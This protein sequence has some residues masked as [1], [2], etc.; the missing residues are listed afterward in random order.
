MKCVFDYSRKIISK[1]Q[2]R[3][4]VC[5]LGV[6]VAAFVYSAFALENLCD[7]LE[8][9]VADR[10]PHIRLHLS[11]KSDSE[12]ILSFLWLQ[13]NVLRADVGILTEK[14]V[15]VTTREQAKIIDD[16]GNIVPGKVFE[17]KP[18][19]I[20][21]VGYDFRSGFRPPICFDNVYS[22]QTRKYF[23]GSG[24]F[25][26][27][28]R[29]EPVNVLNNMSPNERK[30]DWCIN[31]RGLSA[32]L[33]NG[34]FIQFCPIEIESAIGTNSI[35]VVFRSAG[36]IAD[37]AFTIS[38][39]DGPELVYAKTESV[40]KVAA[41][42]E[43]R[44]I[45]DMSLK[46][47]EQSRVFAK[48]LSDRFAF[49]EIEVWQDRNPAAMP[50]LGGLKN[51]VMFGVG[52][53]VALSVIGVGIV[54][55]ILVLTKSR[56]LAIV[57]AMGC[58]AN[59]VR[60]VFLFAGLRT[61]IIG[62]IAGMAVG[63]GAAWASTGTWNGIIGMFCSNPNQTLLIPTGTLTSFIAVL[64]LS[65]VLACWIPTRRLIEEDPI[66]NLRKE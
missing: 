43:L 54:I 57:Y 27:S 4:V 64:I 60:A 26:G 19:R 58:N 15:I 16:N 13:K 61:A 45:I 47:R 65:C 10:I 8:S 56:Q 48:E 62:V 12:A 5:M 34:D 52:G 38:G 53:I 21:F 22:E 42:Q 50:I 28:D 36:T 41:G 20:Q 9:S 7:A 1:R 29:Y 6:C 32:L 35:N 23:V 46:D 51:I 55:S 17:S 40:R 49:A 18:K 31:S 14:D 2:S 37:S 63:F 66:K 39:D 24:R 25:V 11:E 3:L 59:E 44:R 33:P 30:N